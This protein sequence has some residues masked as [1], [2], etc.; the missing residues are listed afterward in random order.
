MMIKTAF[1]PILLAGVFAAPAATQLNPGTFLATV[2]G[3]ST[4][5]GVFVVD[6]FG[7]TTTRLSI[8]GINW[9]SVGPTRVVVEDP[10]NFLLL[11]ASGGQVVFRVTWSGTAWNAKL[12]GATK[13]VSGVWPRDLT[14]IG[15]WIY[16]TRSSGGSGSSVTNAEIFRLP[17]TGG[18]PASYF[19][20]SKAGIK[21]MPNVLCAVGT[22]VHV[23]MWNGPTTTGPDHVSVSTAGTP[24]M[25]KR[26]YLP[27]SKAFTCR[28]L[29]VL[30]REAEY[31]V[32]TGMIIIGTRTAD[33]LYRLPNGTQVRHDVIVRGCLTNRSNWG[34]SLGLN[35]D[36]GALLLGDML[37]G[38]E[39]RK[40]LDGTWKHNV[41]TIP[42]RTRVSSLSYVM[43]GSL[44]RRTG[45]GCAQSNGQIACNYVAGLPTRGNTRFALTVDTPSRLGFL[46]IGATQPNI[47][48][49]LLA[50]GCI[51]GPDLGFLG[52]AQTTATGLRV[53]FTI[54][55][56]V[57][58]GAFAYVQW[59]V[60]DNKNP[61][62]YVFSD[63]RYIRP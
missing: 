33:V 24:V 61:L 35:S 32:R 29:G 47:K 31:D 53:A 49:G 30:P 16:F 45:A 57:P 20:L 17:A 27:F 37:G 12:L 50:P 60:R 41:Q 43:S 38:I 26:G 34:E 52:A 51:I 55:R 15:K 8:A 58:S 36:T 39:E 5:R 4:V 56:T 14:R 48:L 62:G 22:D 46:V 2:E 40:C 1:L 23:F 9:S 59:A 13:Y 7:N 10:K 28:K 44:Y 54:P 3:T 6:R 19:H 21:G 18:T 42:T 25:T 63:T 11:G